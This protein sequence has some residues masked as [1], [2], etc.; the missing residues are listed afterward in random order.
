MTI[1]DL[2]LSQLAALWMKPSKD[3]QALND[4]IRTLLLEKIP[5][6]NK[7]SRES[8]VLPI[9][10]GKTLQLE[11]VP[12]SEN[13]IHYGQY[14]TILHVDKSYEGLTQILK[15]IEENADSYGLV[16]LIGRRTSSTDSEIMDINTHDILESSHS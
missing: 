7:Y 11:L 3:N 13:F 10:Q 8:I 1:S 5:T 2:S 6:N 12:E 16:K 4:N 14:V 15:N 9:Y